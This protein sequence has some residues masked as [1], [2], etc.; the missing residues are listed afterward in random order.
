MAPNALLLKSTLGRLKFARLNALIISARNCREAFSLS[1]VSLFTERST[2]C[3]LGPMMTLRPELPNVPG[4]GC[5]NAA[6]LNHSFG[7]REP[8][9]GSPTRLGRSFSSPVPLLS[10]LRKGVIGR[11]LWPV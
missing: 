10:M 6:L 11:P 7:L 9:F 8:E 4:S 3:R 5:R 2:V 1:F